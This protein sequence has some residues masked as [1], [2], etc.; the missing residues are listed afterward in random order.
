MKRPIV[1]ALFSACVLTCGG[2]RAEEPQRGGT[3]NIVLTAD[4]RSLDASRTDAITETV[5]NHIYEPLV[6]YRND[7]TIGPVLAQSWSASEDGKQYS[8]KIRPGAVF[9]NGDRVLASD[10]KWSWDRR[11]ATAGTQT[12]WP[13]IGNF[14]GT[15]GLKV[16]SVEAADENTVVYTIDAPNTQF[17]IRIADPVCN[18]WVASPKNVGADGKWI[19]GSAIGSGS[20][21]LK[22]WKKEQ[23]VTLSRFAGYVPLREKR[24]G[25]TGDR[26]VYVDEARFVVIPDKTAAETALFAAQV[27]VVST[28]QAS[29]MDDLKGRGAVI[30]L[31][32]GLSF[33]AILIQ[34]SDP[35]LSD[36]RIRRAMAHA[37]DLKQITQVKTAG[38]TEFNPSGVPQASAL[39]DRSFQDWPA[40]DPDAA[41]KLLKEAGYKGQPIK[42]QANQR[43]IGMYE[44]AV[45]AQAML[46]AIGMNVEIETLD[47]GAQLDNY[48]SGKFQMQAFG[49]GS[50]PDPTVIYGMFTG[51]KKAV[52]SYQWDDPKAQ[53]LFLKAIATV[54]LDQR[55]AVF[56]QMH[57]LMGEQVPMIGL[58]YNPVIEA[59]SP[60]LRNY[61]SWA[62]DKPR[63][64][65]VWKVK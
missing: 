10:V 11:M 61:E 46:T 44:N 19:E 48:L 39:F 21:T 13:C 27:D 14:N 47:W 8:F 24:D 30:Q 56:K 12:P 2:A 7:M 60:K 40:Y 57:A 49:Y 4:I 59:V 16:V 15:R 31:A 26:S 53:E 22:E 64:W 38:M 25:Y 29:R 65:G 23:Y 54:D 9:H 5:L 34:T 1:F 28:I 62:L 41:R 18:T 36:V 50:R 20:F 52:A 58:Y 37:M 42:I 51:S 33:S 55:K 32:P 63:A 35:L 6:S 45:L 3:L 17:L 43:Y